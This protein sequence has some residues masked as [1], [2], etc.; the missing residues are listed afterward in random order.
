MLENHNSNLSIKPS[1][2][3]FV[4]S[5]TQQFTEKNGNTTN[6]KQHLPLLFF[7]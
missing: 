4:S 1:H 2:H 6:I 7:G 5:Q 3:R